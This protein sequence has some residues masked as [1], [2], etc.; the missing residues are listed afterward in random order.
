MA[1]PA[2]SNPPVATTDV[3][4]KDVGSAIDFILRHRGLSKLTLMGWSWGATIMGA[5]TADHNDKVE[6]LV[7]YAPG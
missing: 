3:A 7:L 5:Y 6:R 4:V 1:Q 2:A